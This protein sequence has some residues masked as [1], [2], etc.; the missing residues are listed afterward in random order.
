MWE[1]IH[2]ELPKN[3]HGASR[4]GLAGKVVFTYDLLWDVTEFYSEVFR[5]CQGGHE[6]KIRYVHCHEPGAGCGYDAVEQ[7][8][9]SDHFSGG[10]GHFAGVVDAVSAD[11]KASAI[12]LLF[13]RSDRAYKLAVGDVLTTFNRDVGFCNEPYCVGAFDATANALGEASKFIC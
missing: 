4:V 12:L 2:A 8:F 6:V 3:V 9:G 11:C 13:F 1:T 5:T 10:H 7:H